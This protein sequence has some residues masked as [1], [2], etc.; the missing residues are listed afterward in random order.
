[1]PSLPT[2]KKPVVAAPDMPSLQPVVKK[3]APPANVDKDGQYCCVAD[4]GDKW[5]D[6]KPCNY[7]RSDCTLK[8]EKN[9]NTGFLGN[10]CMLNKDKKCVKKSQ[11]YPT[12]C[13]PDIT[14]KFCPSGGYYYA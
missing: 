7:D 10:Y 1:M 8:N 2:V 5:R 6:C 3:P 14:L 11:N 12:P 9:C 4:S 13:T